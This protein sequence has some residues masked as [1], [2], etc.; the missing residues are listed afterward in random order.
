MVDGWFA[1]AAVVVA[2]VLTLLGTIAGRNDENGQWLRAQRKEA[3]AAFLQQYDQSIIDLRLA[4]AD[5]GPNT[6]TRTTK[7]T[8]SDATMTAHSLAPTTSLQA[9]SVIAILGPPSVYAASKVLSGIALNASMTQLR[10]YADWYKEAQETVQASTDP[11]ISV[12][13]PTRH[14]RSADAA[15]A[16][17]KRDEFIESARKALKSRR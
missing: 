6:I 8:F 3:Y 13:R 4:M 12:S 5:I 9:A 14:E 11:D 10:D 7:H 2:G 17:T 16:A 15:Y 1:L